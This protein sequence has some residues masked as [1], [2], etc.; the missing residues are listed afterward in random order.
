MTKGTFHDASRTVESGNSR[1]MTSFSVDDILSDKYGSSEVTSGQ[2]ESH[3]IKHRITLSPCTHDRRSS[4]EFDSTSTIME[5]ENESE[6][7]KYGTDI[8]GDVLEHEERF[9]SP[10]LCA[11]DNSSMIPSRTAARDSICSTSASG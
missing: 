4:A 10:A 7:A 2:L 1:R 11:E 5:K 6:T 3:D 9:N 8:G